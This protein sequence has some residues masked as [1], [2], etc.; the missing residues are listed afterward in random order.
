MIKVNDYQIYSTNF[1][2]KT[3]QVWKL[4]EHIFQ[5]TYP[6]HWEFSYEAEFLQ[7]AQ[8]RA[9]FAVKGLMPDLFIDYLPYARQDKEIANDATFALYPF[10]QLL[11]SLAFAT[12]KILDPHSEIAT[13]L[14]HRS[15]AA[16]PVKEV[17]KVATDTDVFCYPDAGALR[18]YCLIYPERETVHGDKIR[19]QETGFIES[20]ELHGNVSGKRVLIVDDIC[21]GGATFVHL[22]KALRE[23]GAT[24]I[25]LFVTH[26]IFSKG[27]M[28]LTQAGIRNIYTAKGEAVQIDSNTVGWKKYETFAS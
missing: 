5:T 10:A 20:Y 18:K 13:D 2:D 12:V 17:S 27:L 9:L 14:I 26:G 25:D 8:L 23:R 3:T 21:D 6:I 7:L 16:Y 24:S 15:Q 22:A 11:N 19:N 1:P 4:P 28:P